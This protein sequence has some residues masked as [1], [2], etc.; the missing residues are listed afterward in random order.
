MMSNPVLAEWETQLRLKSN[1]QLA[2]R[3]RLQR[4]AESPGRPSQ[5]SVTSLSPAARQDF[6]ATGLAR[7]SSL[8]RTA[9]SRVQSLFYHPHVAEE[10]CAQV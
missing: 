8:A 9:W 4:L 10:E 1:Q 3:L 7:S 6:G 2:E 5:G